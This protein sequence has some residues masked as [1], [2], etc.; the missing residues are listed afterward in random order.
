MEEELEQKQTYLRNEIIEKGYDPEMFT[1]Y[2]ISI[3]GEDGFDLENWSM[4]ELMDIVRD[5]KLDYEEA[6]RQGLIKEDP[7]PDQ[8]EEEKT[9]TKQTQSQQNTS[10]HSSPTTKQTMQQN[11][12]TQPR[13]QSK[14]STQQQQKPKPSSN[15]KQPF[16]S[17]K[18]NSSQEIKTKE[19]D[20]FVQINITDFPENSDKN[21]M[22][23][24]NKNGLIIPTTTEYLIINNNNTK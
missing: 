4:N 9:I 17:Q 23:N 1:K 8:N 19:I 10:I 12:Q 20:G 3:K 6:K 5:F 15:A 2:I 13:T 14:T 11:Q 21:I 7:I 24:N 22:D 16:F 18:S